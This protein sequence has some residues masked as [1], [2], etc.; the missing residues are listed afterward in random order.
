MWRNPL[1]L[2]GKLAQTLVLA[3]IVGLIFRDLGDD[4]KGVQNREGSLF[5]L[6]VQ[7][8]FGAVMGIITIFGERAEWG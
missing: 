8:L 7:G 5:F 1:I 4:L 3:L 6:M 2:K